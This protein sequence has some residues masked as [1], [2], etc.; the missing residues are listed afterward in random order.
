[1][2]IETYNHL[3]QQ[4][5]EIVAVAMPYD[6]PDHVRAFT[7]KHSLP[8]N[9]ALDTGGGLSAAFNDVRLTPTAILI[10]KE[11][12][13]LSTTVGDLDFASLNNQIIHELGRVS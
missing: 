1:M 13:I 4:G 3:H 12:N 11:G 9:V 6:D 7:A 2:L 10:D 5:F 8:F